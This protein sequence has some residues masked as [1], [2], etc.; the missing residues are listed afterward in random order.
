MYTFPPPTSAVFFTLTRAFL[1]YFVH[2]YPNGQSWFTKFIC[3]G[4]LYHDLNRSTSILSQTWEAF[5]TIRKF[6]GTLDAGAIA[7]GIEKD[8]LY[9]V[10]FEFNC[11]K[12]RNKAVIVP[13]TYLGRLTEETLIESPNPVLWLGTLLM[14]SFGITFLQ[15]KE[16]KDAKTPLWNTIKSTYMFE[17]SRTSPTYTGELANKHLREVLTFLGFGPRIVET[18]VCHS[19][20]RGGG[21]AGSEA[22]IRK[23][24]LV[25]YDLAGLTESISF[26][27]SN[28]TNETNSNKEAYL[29]V[30]A[31]LFIESNWFIESNLI[32][33]SNFTF[34][35]RLTFTPLDRFGKQN[36]RQPQRAVGCEQHRSN[37]SLRQPISVPKVHLPERRHEQPALWPPRFHHRNF[38]RQ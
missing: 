15:L 18:A 4:T 12:T 9:D 3:Y 11:G 34:L 14:E 26:F 2:M 37:H 31:N 38:V 1:S 30:K 17:G 35:T 5:D 6:R 32:L 7:E 22:N 19:S 8:D 25:W 20:F 10:C 29:I 13:Q 24:T 28:S 36:R 33:L 21:A 27:W 23:G 16:E